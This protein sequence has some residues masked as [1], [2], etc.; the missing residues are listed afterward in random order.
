[1]IRISNIHSRMV[2]VTQILVPSI[3]NDFAGKNFDCVMAIATPAAQAFAKLA[4][5]HQIF[6]AV[7]DPV[8]AQ[9]TS[10]LSKPDKEYYWY[11]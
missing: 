8:G 3:A 6:S 10:S 4:T 1:M 9:L 2:K 5:R 11:K 7:T